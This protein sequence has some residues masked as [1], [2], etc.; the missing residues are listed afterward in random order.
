MIV[1]MAP[2]D[3]ASAEVR[4]ALGIL[5]EVRSLLEKPRAEVVEGCIPLLEHA[6]DAM[7]S[8]D[9][10]MQSSAGSRT[11]SAKRELL[12]LKSELGIVSRLFREVAE[13]YAGLAETLQVVSG[14]YGRTGDRALIHTGR[15]LGRG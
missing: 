11:G 4:R 9:A 14:A 7:K 12:A 13:Y 10:L 5:R 3:R 2:G 8:A 1:E 6:A 15:T